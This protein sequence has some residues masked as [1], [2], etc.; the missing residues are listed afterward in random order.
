MFIHF[1]FEHKSSKKK[2][3]VYKGSNRKA[4]KFK[5]FDMTD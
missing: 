3:L 5:N 2:D 4:V 1:N